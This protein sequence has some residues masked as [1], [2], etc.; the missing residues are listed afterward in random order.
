MARTRN[1]ALPKY[2]ELNPRNQTYYYKNPAMPENARLSKVELEAVRLASQLNA[3]YRIQ[4]EQEAARLEASVNL[5][6][7]GFSDAFGAFVEKYISDYSL[8]SSTAQLLHQRR[9]RLADALGKI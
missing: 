8:K 7:A 4:C 9:Q 1:N 6:S 2:V 5:G 3:R